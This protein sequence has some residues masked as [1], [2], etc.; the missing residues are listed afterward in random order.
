[1]PESAIVALGYVDTLQAAETYSQ[2][3]RI[4]ESLDGSTWIT[5]PTAGEILALTVQE[6]GASTLNIGSVFVKVNLA[7]R[8]QYVRMQ[9]TVTISTAS[10]DIVTYAMCWVF[11]PGAGTHL[12]PTIDGSDE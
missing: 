1:M 9:S 5:I 12:L 3:L 10:V 2:R 7:K 6:T 4:Q 8:A 11:G